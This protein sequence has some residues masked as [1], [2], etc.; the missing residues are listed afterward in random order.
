MN[1]VAQMMMPMFSCCG[2]IDAGPEK[3]QGSTGSD[4][5]G[6][7]R[8]SPGHLEHAEEPAFRHLFSSLFMPRAT[9]EQFAWVNTLQEVSPRRKMRSA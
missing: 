9:A 5:N 4:G 2:E 3:E 8:S 7:P 6:G 1:P